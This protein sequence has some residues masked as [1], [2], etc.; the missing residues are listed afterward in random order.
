[1]TIQLYAYVLYYLLVVRVLVDYSNTLYTAGIRYKK[2][3]APNLKPAIE[4]VR[5]DLFQSTDTL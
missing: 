2:P 3:V 4:Q 1:M 5:D